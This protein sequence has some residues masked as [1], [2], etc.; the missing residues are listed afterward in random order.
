[1][2]GGPGS[3]GEGAG[4]KVTCL[5]HSSPHLGTTALVAGRRLDGQDSTSRSASGGNRHQDES[6]QKQKKSVN[7][8]RKDLP[9]FASLTIFQ[10]G[11]VREPWVSACLHQCFEVTA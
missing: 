7:S 10:Q 11:A 4:C 6:D 2:A 3:A 5:Q 9:G 1:M 8:S